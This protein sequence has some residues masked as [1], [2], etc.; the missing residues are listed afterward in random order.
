MVKNLQKTLKEPIQFEGVGLHNGVNANLCLKPAEVNSGIKF[1]RT[2][3]DDSKNII[4][5]N[6]K[7][8]SSPVLC[9]KLKNSHGVTVSTVPFNA[10]V[11]RLQLAS[12][13]LNLEDFND[14]RHLPPELLTV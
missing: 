8:V 9:T 1:K 4:E 10:S 13:L 11:T 14:A 12:K 3:V 6:Y 5:A 7:Y 2:D